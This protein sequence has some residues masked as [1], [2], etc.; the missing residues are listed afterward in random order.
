VSRPRSPYVAVVGA[1]DAGPS[2][3]ERAE[4]VGRRL[5]EAGAVIVCGGLGGV[6]HAAA[7]GCERAGGI[8]VGVLPGDDLD[9]ASPHLGVAIATGMGEARNAVIARTVDSVIAVGGGYGTLSE[10]A[11]AAKMGKLVVGLDTWALPGDDG[12]VVHADSAEDAVR[13]ALDAARTRRG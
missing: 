11:L 12:A 6:M 13:L 5:A 7:R 8:S 4:E 3:I 9:P 2:Q 1:G 10:I